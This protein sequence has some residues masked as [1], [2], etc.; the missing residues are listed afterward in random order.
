MT[1]TLYPLHALH[2][3]PCSD[4]HQDAKS[5]FKIFHQHPMSHL[6]RN[7]W[8]DIVVASN[9]EMFIPITISRPHPK[10]AYVVSPFSHYVT[11]AQKE[12][13]KLKPHAL[14]WTLATVT[15]GLGHYLQRGHIEPI[16][17][18]NNWLL[19]TNLYPSLTAEQINLLHSTLL[20]QYP[21]M[22]IAFRSIDETG[23]EPL[24][25]HLLALGYTP[26]FS[27]FVW[28]QDPS[29]PR[30][31]R[32]KSHR[33]D[34]R[35]FH[36]SGYTIQ[37]HTSF[38]DADFERVEALYT[39]LYISKYSDLNPQFTAAFLKAQCHGSYLQLRALVKNGQIDA[40]FGYYT[41]NGLGTCPIFGYDTSLPQSAGLYRSL[42]W[43]WAQEAKRLG[44]TIHASSGVG[45]F[46]KHRGALPAIEYNMVYIHH[47][48]APMRRR[49]RVL[50][51]LADRIA[52]P[53]IKRHEL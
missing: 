14:A 11:Y 15:R 26:V 5:W 40:V 19:S 10:N 28:Y 16:V 37:S 39:Q 8:A 7:I 43:V 30:V 6:I 44:V 41:R 23:N 50:K 1:L 31:Q 47:L 12:I 29:S 32:K 13:G 24:F 4:A 52:V 51:T 33:S 36:D 45:A 2:E 48:P 34:G 27:R 53:L 25:R 21:K 49:W 35:L 22:P 3:I 38:N 9:E 17:Y 42:S 46:K 18:V 20:D